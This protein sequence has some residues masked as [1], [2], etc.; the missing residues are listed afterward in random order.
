MTGFTE[1][2]TEEYSAKLSE[3]SFLKALRQHCNNSH[4]AA[5][6]SGLFTCF[7]AESDFFTIDP[8]DRM[9]R[10]MFMVDELI[11][12]LPSWK[13][14]PFRRKAIIG[15]TSLA[16][17]KLYG[18][19]DAKP[20]VMLPYDKGM[21]CMLQA[22]SFYIGCQAAEKKIGI[23][24]LSNGQ[25]RAWLS[26]VRRV[27]KAAGEKVD[28][29]EP[30][31]G[32]A[33]LKAVQALGDIKIDA[34]KLEELKLDE[35]DLERAQLFYGRSGTPLEFLSHALDPDTNRVEKLLAIH[36][37]MP[38]DREVWTNAPCLLISVA[39]Y[40]RLHEEGKIK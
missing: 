37:N 5:K 28:G 13:H 27:A 34:K 35:D 20:Y 38:A 16:A 1:F 40:K 30:D 7:K 14:T 22:K 26:T 21:L 33:F 32:K 31:S 39:A 3:E 18:P 23:T 11:E 9:I 2:L 19:K 29:A 36:H 4:T 15:Y 17:A 10:S 8:K 6:T 25:L 24:S 12:L